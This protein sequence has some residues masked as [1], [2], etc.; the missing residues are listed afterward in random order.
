MLER[1]DPQWILGVGFTLIAAG[2]LWMATIPASNLHVSAIVAPLLVVGA[3]FALSVSAVTSVAVNTVPIH[4]AGMASGSTSLLR[5]FGFTL[6]PAVIG[7][8]ALSRAATEIATKAPHLPAALLRAAGPLGLNS[9]AKPG[10][11]AVQKL[12]FDALGHAYSVGFVICGIAG[13][14]AAALTVL[15]LRGGGSRDAPDLAT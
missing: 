13:L 12:A 15:A 10:G 8:V 9:P 7:A 14:V 3:G 11:P 1:W 2:D 4:L 6:G 5:D